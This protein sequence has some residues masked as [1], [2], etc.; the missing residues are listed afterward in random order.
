[1]TG[2]SELPRRRVNLNPGRAPAALQDSLNFFCHPLIECSR[3]FGPTISDWDKGIAM[4]TTDR[5]SGI[6]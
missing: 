1:M 3:D 4:Y 2:L 6:I 5:E